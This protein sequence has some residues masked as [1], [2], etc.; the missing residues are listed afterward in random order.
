M[1]GTYAQPWVNAAHAKVA[2]PVASGTITSMLARFLP[3]MS[4]RGSLPAEIDIQSAA[5]SR[6][7]WLRVRPAV[8]QQ[9]DECEQR[10]GVR[11]GS[12]SGVSDA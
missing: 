6:P 11:V 9:H 12:G 2:T 10:G 8:G 1:T 4:A 5:P 3:V 7:N